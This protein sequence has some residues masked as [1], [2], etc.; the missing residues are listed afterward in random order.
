MKDEVA[1]IGAQLEREMKRERD[2]F[3]SD[4]K[5]YAFAAKKQVGLRRDAAREL[6]ERETD[7]LRR[8]VK[9]S[10]KSDVDPAVIAEAKT[11][12]E[13]TEG[14]KVTALSAIQQRLAKQKV[15]QKAAKGLK[16]VRIAGFLF[17]G[18][19]VGSWLESAQLLEGLCS[20]ISNC[21]LIL[22]KIQDLRTSALLQNQKLQQV[23]WLV[24]CKKTLPPPPLLE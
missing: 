23:G 10:M 16:E 6:Q 1:E 2:V 17:G 14:R 22:Q 20:A 9:R 21:T 11:T 15:G 12:F 7:R 3:G 8:G 5:A 18:G 24:V 19:G 4:V 13:T